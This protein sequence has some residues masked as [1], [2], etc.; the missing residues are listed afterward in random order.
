MNLIT[1][2]IGDIHGCFDRLQSLLAACDRIG[3]GRRARFI[4][5]GDYIDRGPD[6][7]LVLDFLIRRQINRGDRFVCLRGHHEEMLTR[8][9]DKYRSDRDLMAWWGNGGEQTL[10]SYGVD[11]PSDLPPKHLDWMR[12]LPLQT[13]DPHRLFVHAGIRPG[14]ALSS[15][16]TGDLLWIREPFLSS[17][18][19]HGVLVVH[20]H[21]PTAFESRTC[22]QTN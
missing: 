21:T 8:A 11:D 1:F 18:E 7:K 3:A 13:I 20:G 6:S 12:S 17:E 22:G 10:E 4:L 5:V 16:A 9:A 15:Q 14:V 2:A 19:D